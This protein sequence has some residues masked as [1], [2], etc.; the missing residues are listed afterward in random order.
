VLLPRQGWGLQGA[1][2]SMSRAL[3]VKCLYYILNLIIC[4]NNE[5]FGLGVVN[6]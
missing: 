5:N 1:R 3:E 2:G 4:I 6:L